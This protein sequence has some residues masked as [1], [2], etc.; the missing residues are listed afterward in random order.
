[1][2]FSA[3]TLCRTTIQAT[4]GMA[5]RVDQLLFDDT[6][7]QVRHVVVQVGGWLTGHRVLVSPT[8]IVWC[9]PTAKTVY[10]NLTSA[11]VGACPDLSTDPSVTDQAELRVLQEAP[12]LVSVYKPMLWSGGIY[13]SSLIT[14]LPEHTAKS[15]GDPHLRGTR[16]ITGYAVAARDATFGRI[17]D[18]VI[19]DVSWKV[20]YLEVDTR[21]WW[22]GTQVLVAP[23]DVRAIDYKS[24]TVAIDM[25]RED[26]EQSPRYRSLLRSQYGFGSSQRNSNT[27]PAQTVRRR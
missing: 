6:T 9:S 12:Y 10:I 17:G 25:W 27:S 15:V 14:S 4:D 16:N 24:R 7:W 19:D 1:M 22:A 2:L 8:A 3:N 23:G 21:V 26:I 20:R 5:G 18:I 13:A 11:Q